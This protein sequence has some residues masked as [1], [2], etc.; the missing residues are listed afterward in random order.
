M[1]GSQP[2]S[3]DTRSEGRADT[4]SIAG[5]GILCRSRVVHAL[6][7]AEIARAIWALVL[8][9]VVVG[10]GTRAVRSRVIV[11]VVDDARS[12]GRHDVGRYLASREMCTRRRRGQVHGWSVVITIQSTRWLRREDQNRSLHFS[13]AM[14][15]LGPRL[16][17]FSRARLGSRSTD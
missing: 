5:R 14:T 17:P 12:F 7:I 6:C 11:V 10:L 8:R 9:R 1:P 2:W 16:K 4:Y 15:Q 3:C 13:E